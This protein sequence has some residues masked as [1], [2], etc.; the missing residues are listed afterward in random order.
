MKTFES[1]TWAG[2]LRRFR[3]LAEDALRQY[4]VTVKECH[5]LSYDTNIIYRVTAADGTRYALRLANG[6]WRTA[7]D[8]ESE[9]S[10]LN[11]LARDTAIPVPRIL[12]TRSGASLATP[13][14]EGTPA[15]HHAILMS[16][17][18][19]VVLG[20]QLSAANLQKMGEL[21]AQLHQ[22]GKLW[23]PPAGFTTRRFEQFLS[24]GEEDRFLS[25]A[26]AVHY[27]PQTLKMLQLM[28]QRVESAYAALDPAD[29]RVIHCDLWH[30]NIKIHKGVLYPFDFEDTIWGYRLHDIAM[31][32]LDLY[33]DI[34]ESEHYEALLAAFRRGYETHLA[35]PDGDMTLLQIGRILWRIN[36]YTRYS[37]DW[38][39][40]DATFN[41]H[42]FQRYLDSGKL[43]PPL[44]T[45]RA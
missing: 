44:R 43:L 20:K 11:A 19:G 22:H 28:R 23:Q 9:V 10:W 3:K 30:D 2:K 25:D 18:P 15:G 14:A 39:K 7:T 27:D 26:F 4:D 33:E 1:L 21:F 31:A 32:M 37:V 6:R 8:A 13:Q 35:W 12:P 16:W 38:L 42:L 34:G 41:A 29:L 5:L 45:P 24:R 36:F 40:K 17:Q